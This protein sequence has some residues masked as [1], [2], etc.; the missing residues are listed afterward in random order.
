MVGRPGESRI[1][2]N[3]GS[4]RR[5]GSGSYVLDRAEL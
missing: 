5:E 2:A 3:A 4:L 1:F